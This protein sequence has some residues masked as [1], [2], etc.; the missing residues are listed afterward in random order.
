MFEIPK[1]KRNFGIASRW[2][3]CSFWSRTENINSHSNS[4]MFQLFVGIFRGMNQHHM[5]QQNTSTR[6]LNTTTRG[7]KFNQTHLSKRHW[8]TAEKQE[9]KGLITG[10]K[11]KDCFILLG[12]T[13]PDICNINTFMPA[14]WWIGVEGGR[15]LRKSS[16]WSALESDVIDFTEF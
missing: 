13:E 11:L 9:G 8:A 16:S 4:V 14:Q 12:W 2:K 7:Q 5:Q 1:R 10:K 6:L 3:K 15:L